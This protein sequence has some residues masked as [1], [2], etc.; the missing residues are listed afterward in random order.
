MADDGLFQL[1][2]FKL[3]SGKTSAWKIECDALADHEWDALAVMLISRL[4]LPFADVVGVERGGVPFANALRR[5]VDPAGHG[6]VLVVDD[7]WTTGG[8]LTAEA[9]ERQR[10]NPE[11]LVI[12]AV[13][14]ARQPVKPWVTALFQMPLPGR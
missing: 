12:G 6:V 8:S 3:A 5:Y 4:P 9:K 10:S 14:F 11:E 7:V 13:A 2:V 1:G